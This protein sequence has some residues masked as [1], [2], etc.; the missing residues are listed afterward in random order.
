[1]QTVVSPPAPSDEKL[2]I[3]IAGSI[4]LVRREIGIRGFRQQ[5]MIE[6]INTQCPASSSSECDFQAP[7]FNFA[8][9]AA[10]K[11]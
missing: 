11:R 10:A 7:P 8:R 5:A 6:S 1:M 4:Q 3:V 2:R 9:N